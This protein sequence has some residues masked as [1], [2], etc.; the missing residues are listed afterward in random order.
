M[1]PPYD[2]IILGGGA[3][4]CF[5]AIQLKEKNPHAKV[6]L[7]ERGSQLLTK[8]KISGGGRC[9]VTH[10][11]FNPKDLVNFYPRGTKELLG[12]FMRFQPLD[13][14]RWLEDKGVELKTETDGRMFPSSNSSST[15][16]SLFTSLLEQ[17]N[18]DIFYQKKISKATKEHDLFILETEEGAHFSSKALLLATGSHPSGY[19][20]AESW[21]HQIVPCVPSLFTFNLNPHPFSEL[22]G[23][24]V[25]NVEVRIEGFSKISRG[26]LL[27]THWGLSGPAVLKLSAW[28]ARFLAEK[29]YQAEVF[30]NWLPNISKEQL[31][32]DWKQRKTRTGK[33]PVSS[34]QPSSL[35]KR[36]WLALL[37]KAGLTEDTPLARLSKSNEAHLISS[38]FSTKC[39]LEGK[40]TYKQEF[41]TAGGIALQGIDMRRMESKECKSLYFAGEILDI[42]GVTGGFNFQNAWTTAWIAAL[43][44]SSIA[45]EQ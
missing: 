43:S 31:L 11:C 37:E 15:I 27:L 38:L 44:L 6:A 26:P 9:N 4:G 35:P 19:T 36:L 17:Y 18:V 41:V 45:N 23:V 22:P 13:M 33:E 32:L 40:T 16:I 21:G 1:T 14:V 39:I 5:A 3:A 20:L 28:A 7:I 34:L 25:E 12:P 2:L 8:V 24:A 30:I 10:N 42:D 29:N